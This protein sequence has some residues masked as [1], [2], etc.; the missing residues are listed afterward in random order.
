MF[1]SRFFQGRHR[2]QDEPNI[3][4]PLER[5]EGEL[6]GGSAKEV[7]KYRNLGES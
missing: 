4:K 1:C 5:A 7:A 3:Q 2:Q 6:G